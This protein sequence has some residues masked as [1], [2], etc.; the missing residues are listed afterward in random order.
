MKNEFELICKALNESKMLW[1]VWLL[2]DYSLPQVYVGTGRT[3]EV[4]ESGRERK[5]K[6]REK[7]HKLSSGLGW[8]VELQN[9]SSPSNLIED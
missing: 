6:K 3:V 9:E 5:R 8:H 7:K 4:E 1:L 2:M